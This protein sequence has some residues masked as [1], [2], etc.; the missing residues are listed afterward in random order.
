MPSIHGRDT[1]FPL[2]HIKPLS[3]HPHLGEVWTNSE[4]AHRRCNLG[5]GDRTPPL[6]LGTPSRRW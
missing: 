4:A 5:R 1:A 3:T 2:D 6:D